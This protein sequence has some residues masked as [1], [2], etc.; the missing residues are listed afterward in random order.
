MI[1]LVRIKMLEPISA[2]LSFDEMCM[3]KN[4]DYR[5]SY[6]KID[7]YTSTGIKKNQ[8]KILVQKTNNK[9]N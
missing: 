5:V 6:L 7:S 3:N 4:P 1:Y 8:I 2:A 9:S